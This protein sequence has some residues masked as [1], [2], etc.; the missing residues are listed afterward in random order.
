VHSVYRPV[1]NPLIDHLIRRRRGEL[2]FSMIPRKGALKQCL[3]VLRQGGYIALLADQHSKADGIWVPFLGR[4]ASTTPGP[5]LLAL[6][7]GAP[8]VMGCAKRLPG[9][10]RFEAR[11]DP[12]MWVTPT[13]DRQADVRRITSAISRRMED[14]VRESPDQWLWLHRRWRNPPPE[15]TAERSGDV[16]PAGT[17]D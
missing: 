5:A 17:T 16:G 11:F 4:P 2:G 10:Y 6:R 14:Y 12:P 15:V 7:T 3:R 1:K 9:T 13:G 8:I